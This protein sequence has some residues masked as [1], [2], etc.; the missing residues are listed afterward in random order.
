MRPV[1]VLS[2]V[3]LII[4]DSAKNVEMYRRVVTIL[5]FRASAQS[6]WQSLCGYDFCLPTY[7]STCITTSNRLG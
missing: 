4:L 6:G 1:I 3:A 7:R 2:Y 5:I